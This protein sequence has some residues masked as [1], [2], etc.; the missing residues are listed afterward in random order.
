MRDPDAKYEFFLRSPKIFFWDLVL[1]QD[2]W[3]A[4]TGW[5]MLR[6]GP[7]LFSSPFFCSLYLDAG[8]PV[9]DVWC[10]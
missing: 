9:R 3:G 5:V 8:Y 2:R 1:V 6:P 10:A 7:K 4:K